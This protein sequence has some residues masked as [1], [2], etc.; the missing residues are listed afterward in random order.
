MKNITSIEIKLPTIKNKLGLGIGM[1]MPWSGKIGFESNPLK[2]DT[3]TDNMKLFFS[4]YSD[5]FNYVF[6]AF[7]PKNRNKLIAEEYFAAYDCLF[8]HIPP[9]YV[10]AFHHTILNMGATE[11]YDR[12]DIYIFTNKLIKRYNFTWVVEDLGLWSINGKTVPFP[13]PPFMTDK[14]LEVCIKNIQ[15]IQ[16]NLEA[17]LCVEFPGFTEGT[18]FFIGK[19]DAFNYFRIIAEETGVAVTIDIGHILSYQW[20]RGNTG[21]KM[22][23]ELD[24]LPL[25]QCFE[26]HLSGCQITNGKFRDLHHGVL[27]N[28]QISLLEFLLPLCPNLKAV[29]YEDPKYTKNGILIPKAQKNF[30]SMMQIVSN[31]AFS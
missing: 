13:L 3:I 19:M 30:S 31:W 4:Q 18:N 17:P 10:R 7:Q 24:S 2:G 9:R 23:H 15:T 14:G 1:D 28:E 11:Q 5:V 12:K 8:D 21:E 6:F 29:T 16:N 20:L 22:F 25:N 27:L 26:F